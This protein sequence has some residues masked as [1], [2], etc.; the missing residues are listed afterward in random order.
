VYDE[1]DMFS[2]DTE[3]SLEAS[4]D[5][6]EAETGAEIVFYTQHDPDITEDENLDKAK[7]LIDEWGIGRSGFDD[8]LVLM[9]ALDPDPGESRVSL[10]GGS[11]FLGAYA[12]EDALTRIIDDSFVPS[13]RVGDFDSAALRTIEA[14]DARMDADGSDRLETLRVVN[15]ALGLVVAPLALL[16]TL[17]GAW[18]KWRRDG[19]DPALTDSPSILM[20]GPPAEMTPTLATVVRNGTATGHSINTI[21][22]DLA[23]TGRL[24]FHNLDQVSKARSDDDPDPLTDPA[25]EVHAGEHDDRELAGPEREA[26]ERI[27]QH[28]GGSG[29]LSRERLWEVNPLLDSSTRALESAAVR[30]G[31]LARPPAW[32]LDHQHGGH[33][34]RPRH[35]RRGG[36]LPGHLGA[37]DRR[38]PAGRGARARWARHGRVR[39]GHEP[40]HLAGRLRRRHAQGVPANAQ[41]DDGPGSQHE[42]GGRADGDRQAGRH[43]RQGGGVGH[44]TRT[45]CRGRGGA[46]P[47]PRAAAA[48]HRLPHRRV[49]PALAR[50]IRRL[51][52]VRRVGR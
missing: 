46:R 20:A 38:G 30:I 29:R 41:E 3:A 21:L 42:R 49:L 28:A 1:A 10:Y 52:F 27:R 44:G 12:N 40:A 23:R 19:D 8:G 7:A 4:I 45:P 32:T 6:I 2:A 13:A 14:L 11:G 33:R 50:L 47:R 26:W 51:V 37:D 9:V 24:S 34:H 15:G 48:R 16:A 43:A 36:R 31:W 39:P 22:A 5:E 17:G 25:I 18:W 35:R